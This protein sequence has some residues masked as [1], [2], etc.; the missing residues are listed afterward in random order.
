MF[1]NL[2]YAQEKRNL[3]SKQSKTEN[4]DLKSPCPTEEP[5]LEGNN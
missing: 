4:M 2:F 1:R 5:D 3:L